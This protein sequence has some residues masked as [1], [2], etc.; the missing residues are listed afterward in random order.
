MTEAR[1]ELAARP[2]SAGAARRFVDS[3]LRESNL[4]ELRE[5]VL[6]LTSEVVTNAVIHAHTTVDLIVVVDHSRVRVEVS[7]DDD[8]KPE[9]RRAGEQ[10]VSGRGL[11]LVEILSVA[12]GV[13]PR[14]R[15]KC[16]WFEVAGELGT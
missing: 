2:E 3:V 11:V 9:L 15:G 14:S 4:E 10:D 16:V 13:R 7:D 5:T 6:L 12:W 1:T 8:R